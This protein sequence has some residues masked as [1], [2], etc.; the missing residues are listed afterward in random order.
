MAYA[1][2]MEE[3]IT[4]T[5][6]AQRR[7]SVGKLGF[8]EGHLVA[9]RLPDGSGW[10]L[11]PGRVVSEAELEILRNQKSISEI[12]SGLDDLASGRTRPRRPSAG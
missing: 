2:L 3:Q 10:V 12:E 8:T 4:L 5:V 11:R 1:V 7:L 9:E 6:D